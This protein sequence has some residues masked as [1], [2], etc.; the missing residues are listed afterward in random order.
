MDF[1]KKASV[2]WSDINKENFVKHISRDDNGFAIKTGEKYI[3]VDL[4]LKESPPD[5]IHE[6]LM[7]N[8]SAIEKTPGGTI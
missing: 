1:H 6:L 5:Y 7:A 4:D 8:C 3:M 2:K